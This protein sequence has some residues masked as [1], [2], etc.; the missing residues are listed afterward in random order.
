MVT[1]KNY[2]RILKCFFFAWRSSVRRKAM[3][4]IWIESS[5]RM[6]FITGTQLSFFVKTEYF[7]RTCRDGQCDHAYLKQCN[8]NFGQSRSTKDCLEP[9]GSLIFQWDLFTRIEISTQLPTSLGTILRSVQICEWH[10]KANTVLLD[11]FEAHKNPDASHHN[12]R[13]REACSMK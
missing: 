2:N 12:V 11:L 4:Y 10:F 5:Q 6:L 13:V 3:S 9:G 7:V 8:E 1:G